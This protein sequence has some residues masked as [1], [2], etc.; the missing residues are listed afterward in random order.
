[1]G[2]PLTFVVTLVLRVAALLFLLRF[3]L[4]AVHASF[5]NPVS[6]GIVRFTNPVLDPMRKVLRPYRNLDFA[7]FVTAWVAHMLAVTFH[8]W[9]AGLPIE[10]F[11]IVTDGLRTTLSLVVGIFM[12]AILVSIIMSWIA[13][14]VY[15]PA[16]IIA[17]ELAEPLL[18]PARRILPPLGGIDLS[19]MITIVVL[20]LIQ[21]YV[22]GVVL[23]CQYL[24]WCG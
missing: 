15:S 13:P 9:S 3:V 23:P 22:I 24:S 6:E 10:V 21:G 2:E 20:M 5:Y 17:R 4:Q 8:I 11:A 16:A 1:M 18:A 7:S 12:V 14:Q 19:P